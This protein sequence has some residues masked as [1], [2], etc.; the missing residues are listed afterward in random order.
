M[1]FE[2]NKNHLRNLRIGR[3]ILDELEDHPICKSLNDPFENIKDP[4][5]PDIEV[6]IN[7]SNQT[8][9]ESGWCTEKDLR[10]W[11]EGKGKMVK[12]N[13][14]EEKKKFW[15][16]AV[17]L[18]NDREIWSILYHWRWF[19]KLK[20]NFKPHKRRGD[21]SRS[22]IAK[23]LEVNLK[24]PEK[25]ILDMYVPFIKEIQEDLKH[26]DIIK[27]KRSYKDVFYG[28]NRALYCLGV[29]SLGACNTPETIE[30]L[31]WI[32]DLIYAKAYYLHLLELKIELPDFEWLSSQIY[33]NDKI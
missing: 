30:N 6:W 24:N 20:T 13:T 22:Y 16:Y 17:S 7:P 21:I 8:S 28:I 26:L 3:S 31:S 5:D 25:T 1:N 11:M 12:G 4:R 9:F 14:E 18:N 27:V 32:K 10:D 23:K 33:K 19:K 29:G 15:D 2:R